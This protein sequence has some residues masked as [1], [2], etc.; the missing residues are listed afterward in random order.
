MLYANTLV[1]H[2]PRHLDIMMLP[3]HEIEKLVCSWANGT[4][5]GRIRAFWPHTKA[6]MKGMR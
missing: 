1:E 2:H 5:A 6:S 4:T 3:N